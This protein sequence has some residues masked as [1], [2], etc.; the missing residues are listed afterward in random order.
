MTACQTTGHTSWHP[1]SIRSL[2]GSKSIET[3]LENKAFV[4][5]SNQ[6]ARVQREN[7]SAVSIMS[8]ALRSHTKVST[9]QLELGSQEFRVLH[10]IKVSLRI[11][12]NGVIE[13]RLG[14]HG[15]T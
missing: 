14:P 4:Q 6:L 7:K 12:Q 1:A 5:L 8:Q 13:T 9:E 2:A 10:R 15:Q 3:T 11:R